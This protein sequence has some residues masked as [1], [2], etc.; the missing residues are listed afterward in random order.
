MTLTQWLQMPKT[1]RKKLLLQSGNSINF[2]YR[3]NFDLF[4]CV[5][6]QDLHYTFMRSQSQSKH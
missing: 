1:Q 3:D 2:A 4:P 5:V 6:K